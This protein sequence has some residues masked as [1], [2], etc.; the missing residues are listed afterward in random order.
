MMGFHN[1]DIP[2]RGLLTFLHFD[3]IL[4]VKSCESEESEIGRG[5][6]V[7]W[8]EWDIMNVNVFLFDDFNS[9]DVF[10]LSLIHI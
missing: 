1:M 8:E 5:N 3:K 9:M 4:S 7:K 10:G 2:P 6:L